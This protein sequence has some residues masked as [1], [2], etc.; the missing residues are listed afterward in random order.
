MAIRSEP[1]AAHQK[2]VKKQRHLWW[3]QPDIDK[4]VRPACRV[5]QQ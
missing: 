4:I 2:I 5:R 3:M 1:R